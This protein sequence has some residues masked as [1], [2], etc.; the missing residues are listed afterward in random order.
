MTTL[1]C[2]VGWNSNLNQSFF[3]RIGEVKVT[4]LFDSS[5]NPIPDGVNADFVMTADGIKIRYAKWSDG[6]K[7]F[8]GNFY[9]I[10]GDVENTSKNILRL[11][12]S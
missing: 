2:I 12:V 5:V 9:S 1:C 6:S 7:K 3:I 10:A 11:S 4:V 8:K